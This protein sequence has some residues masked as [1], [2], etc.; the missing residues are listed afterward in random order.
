MNRPVWLIEEEVVGNLI[1]EGVY[2]STVEWTKDGI[3]HKEYISTEDYNEL[4]E[5]GFPYEVDCE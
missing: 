2:Y 4:D 5:L 1:S 3:Y